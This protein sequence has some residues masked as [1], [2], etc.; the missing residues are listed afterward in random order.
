MAT[1]G[2][3]PIGVCSWSLQRDIAGVLEAMKKLEIDHVHLDIGPACE[4]NPEDYLNQVRQQDWT[5]SS[6]MIGFAQEDYSS[7]EAIQKTGGIVP[8]AYWESNQERF[9]KAIVATAALKV[10]FLSSHFGF[11]DMS[12]PSYADK[13]VRR[14]RLLADAAAEQ[15]VVLLMETGQERAEELREFLDML[16]HPSLGVNFD[17]ANMIMYN[18]GDPL[19]GVRIL[20]PWIRHIHIKDGVHT[21]RPGF[22]GPEVLWGTGKV[23][24][25]EFL[26]ALQEIGYAGVLAIEREAGQDRFGDIQR[27][28]TQLRT[29]TPKH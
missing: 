4:G 24:A 19:D 29:Y 11:L 16:N 18:M 23:N 15:G 9:L 17:P 26:G 2:T 14:V 13:I 5:I 25:P 20:A 12:E 28:V 22:L 10:P 3:W 27:A 1:C 6:T 8:D 7:L 21:D